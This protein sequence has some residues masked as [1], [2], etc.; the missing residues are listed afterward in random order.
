MPEKEKSAA[1]PTGRLIKFNM[2]ESYP[3]MDIPSEENGGV[4][5]AFKRTVSE[6]PDEVTVLPLILPEK[7]P[8]SL[9]TQIFVSPDGDD[10]NDGSENSPLKSIQTAIDRLKGMSGGVV[11]LRGGIYSPSE[12]LKITSEHSGTDISPTFISAYRNEKVK[13][14]GGKSIPTDKFVPVS[15][16]AVQKRL[17]KDA[18][19][20]ILVCD[21]FA[22]GFDESDFGRFTPNSRPMLFVNGALQTIARYPNVGSQL[23]MGEVVEVGRV[24]SKHSALYETNHNK[25]CGWT[26]KLSDSRSD[27]WADDSDIWIYGAVYAEWN[28]QHYPVTIDRAAKT[29]SSV[30]PNQYGARRV[31]DNTYS[32]SRSSTRR[33]N[34]ISTAKTAGFTFIPT[35][36]LRK[37]RL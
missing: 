14:N 33:A 37:F 29:L 16:A 31:N 23:V 34:G 15:D 26:I 36:R 27:G 2:P 8:L 30:Q 9:K 21:L 22:L 24:T 11:W 28:L 5:A 13:I 25:T 1:C 12:T 10:A 19:D 35:R 32:C 17:N 4:M 18:A 3:A 7:F 6:L 20:K